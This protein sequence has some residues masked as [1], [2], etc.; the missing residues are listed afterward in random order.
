MVLYYLGKLF[1]FKLYTPFLYCTSTVNLI[2][3]MMKVY[4][5]GKLHLLHTVLI[6]IKKNCWDWVSQ[7]GL[8]FDWL[9]S[10]GICGDL[11]A[12]WSH[13]LLWENSYLVTCESLTVA[14]S[15][16][17]ENLSE[18]VGC[19]MYNMCLFLCRQQNKWHIW[20]PW[21]SISARHVKP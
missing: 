15:R 8:L 20:C 7:P 1:M 21:R 4:R 9:I 3:T 13:W 16:S 11:T 14:V 5:K 18:K 10:E 19:I 12:V 17:Y 6:I 2:R